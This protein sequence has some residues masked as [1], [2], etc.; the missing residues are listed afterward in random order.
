MIVLSAANQHALHTLV[1]MPNGMPVYANSH[2]GASR[3][4]KSSRAELMRTRLIRTFKGPDGRDWMIL[5]DAGKAFVG[6][7]K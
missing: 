7:V 4:G 6:A 2:H 1:H 3:N 5:T